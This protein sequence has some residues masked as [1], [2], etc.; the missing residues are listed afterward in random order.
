MLISKC[1]IRDRDRWHFIQ[2]IQKIIA[3]SSDPADIFLT[4][5]EG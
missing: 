4:I 2:E 1:K 3:P 5:E